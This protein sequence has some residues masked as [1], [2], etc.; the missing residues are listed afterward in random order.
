MSQYSILHHS[1]VY[2]FTIQFSM[3]FHA[4]S[5]MSEQLLR[6]LWSDKPVPLYWHMPVFSA[7]AHSVEPPHGPTALRRCCPLSCWNTGRACRR[8]HNH[9]NPNI[10]R[11]AWTEAEDLQL[12]RAHRVYGN[13]WA[14]IAKFLPGR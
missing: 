8:W 12:I 5:C 2:G 3:S 11:D 14:E 7:E 13:K 4:L 10:K 6:F 9:L 1:T